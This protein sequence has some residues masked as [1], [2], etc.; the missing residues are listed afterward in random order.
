MRTNPSVY[1]LFIKSFK[2]QRMKA[3]YENSVYTVYIVLVDF[4]LHL[5][6]NAVFPYIPQIDEI[7]PSPKS[8]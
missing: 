1:L 7:C 4:N 8:L 3:F 2:K 6:N 5:L